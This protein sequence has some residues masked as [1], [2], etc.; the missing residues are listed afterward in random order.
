MIEQILAWA[1]I[2]SITDLV[3]V[4]IGLAAQLAFGMRWVIQWLM[5]E[6]AGRSVVPEAFWWFS[7]FGG[8]V[9]FAYG[10]ARGEPVIVLGQAMGSFI[11]LRNLWWIYAEKRAQGATRGAD[12]RAR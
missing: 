11:Y 8:L 6:R 3:W 5:S 7:L 4:S 9:L 10:L 12:E 2:E 1:K